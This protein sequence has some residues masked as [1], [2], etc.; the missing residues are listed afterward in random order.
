VSTSRAI[1]FWLF[2]YL[3]VSPLLSSAL[4]LAGRAPNFP[5]FDSFQS[6]PVIW[7]TAFFLSGLFAALTAY[8]LRRNKR[9]ASLSALVFLALFVP[10]FRVVCGQ[11]SFG[12]WIAVTAA[13]LT[14]FATL[15]IRN[16]V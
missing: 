16:E 5:V 1:A 6:A 8:L 2:V 3:A 7:R 4:V 14:I 11:I 10:S 12:I 13:A 9:V 15:R